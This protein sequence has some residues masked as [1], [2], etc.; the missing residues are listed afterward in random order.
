MSQS[1]KTVSSITAALVVLLGLAAFALGPWGVSSSSDLEPCDWVDQMDGGQ[2]ALVL[3]YLDENASD[4]ILDDIDLDALSAATGVE[5]HP[6]SMPCLRDHLDRQR[7][8]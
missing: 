7:D 8:G 5:L 6:D 3:E 1:E 2:L 4:G